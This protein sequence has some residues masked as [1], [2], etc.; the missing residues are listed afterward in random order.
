MKSE[1]TIQVVE[2]LNND[3]LTEIYEQGIF[4]N[5]QTTGYIEVVEFANNIIYHSE[6]DSEEDI[7]NAGGFKEFLIQKRDELI[8]M[9]TK[10]KEKEIVF[11]DDSGHEY[12]RDNLL[13]VIEKAWRY[14]CL[15]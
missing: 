15:T 2:D 8:N 6:I 3:L 14:E 7:E 12:T 10:V 11:I 5:Y 4:Y 9:L 13:E 1:D